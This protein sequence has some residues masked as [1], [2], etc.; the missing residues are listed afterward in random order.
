MSN[1]DIS[2]FRAAADFLK[3]DQGEMIREFSLENDPEYLYVSFLGRRYRVRRS[4]G[5]VERES[6]A[7]T[8][9]G[10]AVGAE[11]ERET[12]ASA[13]PA[14]ADFSEVMTIY[15]I[16]CRRVVNRSLSGEFVHMDSLLKIHG[17]GVPGGGM[18][19]P[20]AQKF[21]GKSDVLCR[22]CERLGGSPYGQ[23]ADV[24]YRI[25]MFPFF[26]VVFEF[27]N[28][29]E[30]FPASAQF[31]FDKNTQQYLYYETVC[32]AVGHLLR[33]LEEEALTNELE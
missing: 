22:A 3:Y 5:Y 9:Q 15:D 32:Y 28:S 20:F 16:L 25:P 30:D 1:Y 17:S 24:S 12:G 4:D 26:P 27:W 23:K 33:R 10:P 2:K 11:R 19:Q 13:H 31:L 6:A 29:D 7:C 21:D 14:E 18:H 8:E